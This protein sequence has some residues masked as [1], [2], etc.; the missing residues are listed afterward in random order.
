MSLIS[1]ELLSEVLGDLQ[2]DETVLESKL[3]LKTLHFKTE[4]GEDKVNIHELAHKCK[5]WAW[6][7]G[8]GFELLPFGVI[9][10]N[11][12]NAEPI[13]TICLT[14]IEMQDKEPYKFIIIEKASQWILENKDKL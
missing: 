5:K 14:A 1:K 13:K 2:E 11:R 3:F 4:Y 7:E 8:Y 10:F 12:F 9:I 6:N